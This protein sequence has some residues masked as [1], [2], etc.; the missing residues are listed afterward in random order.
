MA[1]VEG[2]FIR[3][4]GCNSAE[5][6]RVALLLS[7]SHLRSEDP[8]A[9]AFRSG[10]REHRVLANQHQIVSQ[11]GSDGPMCQEARRSLRGEEVQRGAGGEDRCEANFTLRLSRAGQRKY[12]RRGPASLV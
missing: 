2:V 8:E 6:R 1:A 10:E 5:Q 11:T 12:A 4:E 9:T 3:M 7:I